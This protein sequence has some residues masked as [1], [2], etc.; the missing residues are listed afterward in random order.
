MNLPLILSILAVAATATS[1]AIAESSKNEDKP[2]TQATNADFV[3]L[4][5]S[6]AQG[7]VST[8]WYLDL[9]SQKVVSCSRNNAAPPS[10]TVAPMPVK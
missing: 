4:G 5:V 3:A 6:G 1:V 2:V 10:C 9:K 8:A 7:V